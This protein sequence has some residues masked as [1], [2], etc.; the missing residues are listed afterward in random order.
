MWSDVSTTT[1]WCG[2]WCERLVA[3]IRSRG[4]SGINDFLEDR[5][6]RT[7]RAISK[8]LGE[9]KFA[10]MQI[11]GMQ[12]REAFQ[13]G[14]LRRSAAD[15]LVRSMRQDMRRGWG[16]GLHADRC[17]AT[18]FSHWRC[19]VIESCNIDEKHRECLVSVTEEIKRIG[20]P[21]GWL[22]KGVDDEIIQQAFAKCW[23]SLSSDGHG[24]VAR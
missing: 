15:A 3:A 5:P 2:D 18:A 23:P 12:L 16:V 10:P 14:S 6:G 9:Q 8:E 21:V 17:R 13:N 11:Y 19:M 24:D 1:A 22:P 7:Y 4:Y 20:P